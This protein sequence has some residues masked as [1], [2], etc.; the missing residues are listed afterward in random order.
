VIAVN[1]FHQSVPRALISVGALGIL[2]YRPRK[3]V[4]GERL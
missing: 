2:W 1:Q 4:V 3:T